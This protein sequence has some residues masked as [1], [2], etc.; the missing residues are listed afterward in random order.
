MNELCRFTDPWDWIGLRGWR[1][2]EK[3]RVYR[4]LGALQPRP[5]ILGPR[6]FLL[7]R[8]LF[9][10]PIDELPPLETEYAVQRLM[11]LDWST[12]FK[13]LKF[14]TEE[15]VRD[16]SRLYGPPV[17]S[18]LGHFWYGLLGGETSSEIERILLRR[19]EV[20]IPWAHKWA[21]PLCG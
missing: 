12:G 5:T 20:S 6:A 19:R 18:V 21:G 14:F 10:G 16:H 8:D 4:R 11:V 15:E 9:G 1:R 17:D 13:V 3:S 7:L 2:P